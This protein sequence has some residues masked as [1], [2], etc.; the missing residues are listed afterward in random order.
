MIPEEEFPVT[1]HKLVAAEKER[2]N[3]K[4]RINHSH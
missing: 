4:T 1:Y 3:M 2:Y